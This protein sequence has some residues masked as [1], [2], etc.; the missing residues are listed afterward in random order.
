M[1]NIEYTTNDYALLQGSTFNTYQHMYS[2]IIGKKRLDLIEETTGANLVSLHET[3]ENMNE[4][5]N[6]QT[7]AEISQLKTLENE[8]NATLQLYK[9]TYATYLD[10]IRA[11][12]DNVQLYKNQNVKD[13]NNKIYY[14]NEYGYTRG[15][16]TEAWEK[17]PNSCLQTTPADDSIDIY[18]RMQHG[19]DYQ[20]G[21]P[22]NLDGKII[23]NSKHGQ[24]AWVDQA[25]TKHYYKNEQILQA[26]I[27][28]GG[29]PSNEIT[30]SDEVYNMFPR[31]DDMTPTT[32]CFEQHQQQGMMNKIIQL[33]SRLMSI[34]Q[35]MYTLVE[36]LE[37]NESNVGERLTNEKAQLKNEI[38]NLDH[39]QQQI[40]HLQN[41][42]NRLD[43][44]LEQ[45]TIMTNMKF[46]QYIG[47]TMGA[48]GLVI[49]AAR[50]I[51]S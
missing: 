31:G 20:P 27:R 24:V 32:V 35:E 22:C 48:V 29:C 5:M 9:N 6:K 33:N 26:T 4:P 11:D 17:K 42:V 51:T 37:T 3:M 16:T 34:A 10:N 28:N 38:V 47:W 21:Q 45:T 39:E 46:L 25:G 2:D 49:L 19:L 41:A 1:A 13:A 14:V 44:D 43:G 36:Q 23:K 18:N 7:D 30:V 12:K 40:Q 15:Y 50:H 8:F